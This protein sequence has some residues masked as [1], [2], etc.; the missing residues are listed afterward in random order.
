MRHKILLVSAALTMIAA[1]YLLIPPAYALEKAQMRARASAV[2][3]VQFDIYLPLQHQAE[4]DQL[5]SDLHNPN[6]PKYQKWL[7]PE[8]FKSRF[9]PP[10]SVIGKVSQELSS[11]G[12]QVT[13]V[14]T[15]Y[16]HVTGTVGAV[17]SA[18]STRI[19][20]AVFAN[21]KTTL[22][23]TQPVTLSPE[24]TA[25]GA[26]LM[27]F[28][29]T[30]HMRSHAV[31]VPQNHNS[32]TGP[33]WFDDLKQ[34]YDFP[35]FQVYNGEGVNI[36]ILM[37]GGFN[38]PDMKNYFGHEKLASPNITEV[39]I[40][41]GAPFAFPNS[42]ETHLDIQQAGGMAP[43]AKIVLYNLPDLS[44]FAIT[45]GLATIIESNRV[46]VVNM[47]FG[48][49]ELFYT[50]EYNNGVDQGQILNLY[51]ALFKQGNAQGITFVASSGDLGALPAPALACFFQN[52]TSSCGSFRASV[53]IPA[54]SPHVTGVGGTNLI[55]TYSAL[56]P[57][58]DSA[59]ISEAAWGDP[60]LM[61]IF[62]GTPAKGPYWGSGGGNSIYFKKPWFQNSVNTGS[63]MRTVPDLALQMG[64]CPFGAV[65]PC[66]LNRSA[67]VVAIDG[68]ANGKFFGVIGT[69][70]SAPDFAGLLALKIE[71]LHHRLGNENYDIY[72]LA[73]AQEK[74]SALRVFHTDID[75][76][77]GKYHTKHGYNMVLGNGTLYGKDFILAPNVPS[78]GIP[79]TPSNP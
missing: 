38:P 23:A 18:F 6:S 57:N 75:G 37:T 76:F 3:P 55:T 39:A 28:S 26:V 25:A 49:P 5:L 34:A 44:D 59:Y 78:A 4:L 20:H 43:G 79:Q 50:A 12:L 71:R 64:G 30:I 17:E 61:D 46:D 15:Q 42:L 8:Q 53:E 2:Q 66:P 54:S 58:L 73:A 63:T 41:G 9:A 21:G 36:G 65:T 14:H 7:T 48:G 70:V 77:N 19:A 24:L 68:G 35:S 29:N 47:S 33:Y 16:L 60:L 45:V 13:E 31:L 1:A 11:K 56:N 52:A 40:A 74:G 69:S 22:A 62:Y 67:T 72:A 32:P 10:S 27:G 51:E